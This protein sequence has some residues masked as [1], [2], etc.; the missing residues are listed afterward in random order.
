M[1]NMIDYLT[2]RGDLT[3]SVAPWCAIDALLAA[4]L[5]YLDFHG[6]DDARGWTLEEAK[7][8]DLLIPSDNSSFENRK[9][10]FLAM[11]DSVRFRESRM[12]HFIALTDGSMG[13]QFSAMCLDLPDGSMCVAFRGTD[14]T[15]I[16]WREDFDMAYRVRVPGQEAA[17]Y[18]LERAVDLTDKPIRIVGHSKG[19]NLA[20]Y[21]AACVP[22]KAQGRIE[23]IWSF[24]GPGMNPEIA[25]GEGYARIRPKIRSYIP[26]TS[27][28]GL[29]MEYF[30]PYTVVRSAA[31]GISQHDPMTWQ[32]HGPKFEELPSIDRTAAVVCETLHEWLEASTVEQ[33]AAFVDTLF[34]L[35]DTTGATKMSDLLGE[36]LRSLLT[37]VGNRKD[38]DPETRRVFNRLMAQAVT[39]GFGNVM[40]R[41]RGRKDA[42]DGETPP[43]EKKE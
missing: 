24:D 36:K 31:T 37:M 25:A 19:G 9:Q 4:T 43:E 11:A 39:L 18:Y 21:A 20:V 42:E 22:E 30:E 14:N 8:I 32:V 27:I 28:I 34:Q 13:M 26:Q 41:V 6:T 5:S 10:A 3:L 16:G 15:I 40:D 1:A 33:R 12:H 29:L 17:C 38:V 23:S 7:R 2:W 35:V